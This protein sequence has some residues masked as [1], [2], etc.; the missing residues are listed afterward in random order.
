MIA[1]RAPLFL[2]RKPDFRAKENF[3]D[4]LKHQ[5]CCD[6]NCK[7]ETARKSA[8]KV[9]GAHFILLH[10]TQQRLW[11]N[12]SGLCCCTILGVGLWHLSR[13]WNCSELPY[14]VFTHVINE[15]VFPPKQKKRNFCIRKELNFRRITGDTSMAA[16]PL[17]RNINM[18]TVTSRRNT[19]YTIYI[20]RDPPLYRA[21]LRKQNWH[22]GFC[23]SAMII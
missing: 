17:F 20:L 16:P 7:I 15:H 8:S 9:R 12:G 14:S 2:K 1:I 23:L 11:L 19:I 21:N 6:C 4:V 10:T 5:H 22:G 3:F 18:A 13:G